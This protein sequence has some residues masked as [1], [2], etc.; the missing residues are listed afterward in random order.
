MDAQ[1]VAQV[2]VLAAFYS[3]VGTGYVLVYRASR[4]LNFANGELLMLSAYFLFGLTVLGRGLLPLTVLLALVLAAVL[5]GVIYS[6]TVRPMTGY[7]VFSIVLMTVG[8]AIV[9]RGVAELVWTAQARYPLEALGVANRTLSLPAGATVTA[10]EAGEVGA[11]IVF[12]GGILV[13][14]RLARLGVQMRAA[15]D[16]PVLASQ[17]G[18][19]IHMAFALSW[20]LA[21]VG[22]G[23]AGLAFAA[24]VRLEPNIAEQG[25]RA[26]AVPLAGGLT[27][28]PGTVIAA[29][30]V[31][32]SE[33]LAVRFA[34]PLLAGVVPYLV[35]LA[36]IVLRPWG[37]LGEK[38]ELER[39]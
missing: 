23:I 12:I 35:I 29:L 19:N 28:V 20:A 13:F 18:I 7:P 24:N 37:L 25:L 36:F 2:A 6:A 8:L 31:A 11:A 1:L 38:E 5:A 32:A 22:A 33:N 3:L 30:I 34:D 14:L 15:A 10:V 17:R 4:V 21:A 16:H 39:V 26:L 27:S 9:L